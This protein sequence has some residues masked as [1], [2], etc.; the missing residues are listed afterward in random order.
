MSQLRGQQSTEL[1]LVVRCCCA[2]RRSKD[3]PWEM[4]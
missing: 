1:V 4:P 2:R 3:S